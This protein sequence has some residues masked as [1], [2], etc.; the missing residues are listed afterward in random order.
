MDPFSLATGIAGFVGLAGLFSTC[1]DIIDRVDSYKDFGVVSRSIIAQFEADKLLFKKW[2][3]NVG[4]H[5]TR[6]KEDHHKD[7]DDPQTASMVEKILLSI[8]EIF[9]ATDNTLS[10]M[11]PMTEVDPRFQ[12]IALRPRGHAEYQSVQTSISKRK[13]IGWA[14]RGKVR[15]VAQVQQFGVLVQRLH[16]LAPLD[17]TRRAA[18][19]HKDAVR[20][21]P[22]SFKGIYSNILLHE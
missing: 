12:D 20:E 18:N 11:Q 7:L 5:Q 17:G 6:L 9:T 16:D 2:A 4:I 22:R 13:R 8:Q 1:L 10:D 15:F 3:Q 19:V 21:V 14:L